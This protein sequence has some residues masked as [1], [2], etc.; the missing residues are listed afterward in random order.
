MAMYDMSKFYE[1]AG[2]KVIPID[3][4]KFKSAGLAGTQVTDEQVQMYQDIVDAHFE[5]FK[6]AVISG[7]D[8]T[9]AQFSKVADAQIFHATRAKGVGLIDGVKTISETLAMF[10][11]PGRGTGT[12][13]A[14]LKLYAEAY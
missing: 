9:D 14:K 13:K 12:A 4:G 3:T 11:K 1:Q 2:V 5:D 7:R 10:A 6:S 8:M